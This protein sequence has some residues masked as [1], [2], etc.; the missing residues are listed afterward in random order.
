MMPMGDVVLESRLWGY[1][2]GMLWAGSTPDMTTFN[3]LLA[4]IVRERVVGASGVGVRRAEESQL[5]TSPMILVMLPRCILKIHMVGKCQ[6][7]GKTIENL[8]AEQFSL[9]KILLKTLVLI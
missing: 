8:S 9:S 3:T 1:Y 2:N 6:D 4:T 7:L 5:Q